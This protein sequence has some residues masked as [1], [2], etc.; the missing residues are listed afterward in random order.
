MEDLKLWFMRDNHTFIPLPHDADEALKI[1]KADNKYYPDG[2]KYGALFTKDKRAES[3][4]AVIAR[5]CWEHFERD[6]R[7]WFCDVLSVVST[8]NACSRD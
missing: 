4:A 8:A 7:K 2:W 3:I 6:A 1:I 5:D